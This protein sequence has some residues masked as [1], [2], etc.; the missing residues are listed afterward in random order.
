[1]G[2]ILSSFGVTWAKLIA[3]VLIFLIVYAVLKKKAFG[4]V[5]AMLEERKARIAEAEQNLMKTRAELEG[6]ETRS[7]E[8]LSEANA[9]A[10][11]IVEEANAT[12]GIAAEKKLAKAVIEAQ[13]L[14]A[15]AKDEVE[16]ERQQL[17]GELKRDF[18]RLIV[19]ATGKVSGKILTETDQE[20][21]N[22][23]A[24]SQVGL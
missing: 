7:K 6:A 17:L 15:K 13:N 11:R 23:E 18:G 4:P 8:I 3:Q 21:I 2:D 9:S 1:M 12:A 14:R 22:K 19:E 20:A 24:T 10:D 16:L 5:M